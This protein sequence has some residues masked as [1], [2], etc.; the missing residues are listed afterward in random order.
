M[1]DPVAEPS[2]ASAPVAE[3]VLCKD[4]LDRLLLDG[5]RVPGWSAAAVAGVE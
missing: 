4:S 1:T 5:A 2:T 3:L